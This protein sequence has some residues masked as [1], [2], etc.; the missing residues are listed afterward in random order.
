MEHR[1]V[2]KNVVTVLSRGMNQKQLHMVS[3]VINIDA[4][5]LIEIETF[6]K[7]LAFKRMKF[8]LAVLNEKES[9]AIE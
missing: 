9:A 4:K 1:D 6:V 5:V 7:N 8:R 3:Q 2:P